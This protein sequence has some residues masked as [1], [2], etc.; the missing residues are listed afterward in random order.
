M[1]RKHI[2]GRERAYA[3][4]LRQSSKVAGVGREEGRE[5]VE[6]E[7]RGRQKGKITW[8]LGGGQ[9]SCGT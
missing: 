8:C 3:K 7:G 1:S 4:P 9:V 2:P 5:A 6:E